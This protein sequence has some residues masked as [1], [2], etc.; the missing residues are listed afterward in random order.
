[1]TTLTPDIDASWR[2]NSYCNYDCGYCF[3]RTVNKKKL[4]RGN[5]D[6]QKILS[7]FDRSGLT[8]F[9]L[10][11]G[12][13]PFFHPHF[14]ELCQGLTRKHLI[15]LNTNLS[16]RKVYDFADQIDAQRVRW[17]HCSVHIK[18]L[19]RLKLIDEFI[20]KFKYVEGKGFPIYANYVLYPPFLKDFDQ[21]YHFFKSQ[22]IILWPKLFK[23]LYTPVKIP[24]QKGMLRKANR[25]LEMLFARHYPGAFT[26]QQRQ[27]MKDL[28]DRSQRDAEQL[29]A[30]SKPK[31]QDYLPHLWHDRKVLGGVPSFK[32]QLCGTGKAF[33]H[34]TEQGDLIRCHSVLKKLGNIYDGN[35]RLKPGATPCEANTCICPYEGFTYLEKNGPGRNTSTDQRK[36]GKPHD[37]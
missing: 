1:M 20:R 16:H 7:S 18:E 37:L 21:D 33:V 14:I 8:W 11:T 26:E 29:S 25:A 22:G 36:G 19:Q 34:I 32:G 15:A 31:T 23:G 6:L 35:I 27:R 5:P 17:I 28:M 4:W 13:E 3:G 30:G 2:V 9:I 10:L 12:G 24:S